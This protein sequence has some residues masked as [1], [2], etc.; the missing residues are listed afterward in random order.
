MYDLNDLALTRKCKK[1]EERLAFLDRYYHTEDAVHSVYLLSCRARTLA[2][3]DYTQFLQEHKF[4]RLLALYK[5]NRF[6][7]YSD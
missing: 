4:T 7:V 2:T 5:R 3:V 6:I 1:L